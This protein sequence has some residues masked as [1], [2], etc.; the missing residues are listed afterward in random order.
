MFI[1]P[2]L[3]KNDSDCGVACVQMV[4]NYYQDNHRG[5]QSLT[6]TVDG[7]QVRT[8]ESFFR[9]KGYMVVSGNLDLRLLR[10]FIKLKVPVICLTQGHYIVIVGTYR[11]KIIYNCPINGQTIESTIKF[12]KKWTNISDGACL[13]NWGIVVYL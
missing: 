3:Q 6:N 13:I 2:V 10:Q 9:E 1:E 8:I 5:I 11:D 7:V 12:K 4:L